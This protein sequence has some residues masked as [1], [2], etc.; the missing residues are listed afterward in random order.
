M[1]NVKHYIFLLS[2]FLFSWA[3][4]FA[5]QRFP[6]PEFETDYIQPDPTTPEPR[7][8][9]FEYLDLLIL[10]IVL[11]LAAYFALK[12]RSRK[13]I[14]WLSIFSLAYFG[15]YRE[16]C[17][18]SVGSVQNVALTLFSSEYLISISVLVFFALPLLFSLFFG[19]VFCAAACPLGVIQDLVILKPI[20]I[21]K[22]LNKVLSIFPYLYLGL[23]VLYAA[24]GTDFVICKYDPFIGFYRMG[25]NF[26]M[27]VIGISLL[28][29][30]L[31]VARPYCRFICPYGV[32]LKWTSMFS[33]YHLSITPSKCTQC[34]LCTDSCPFDAIDKPTSN[35]YNTNSRKYQKGF[36]INA[37]LLPLW[38]VIG[39]YA[40]SS[41]HEYLSTVHPDVYLA[42][43]LV[44]NPD[45]KNDTENIDIQTFMS[46][47]KSMDTLVSEAKIIQDKF[48]WGGWLLGSF[49]GLVIGLT[50]LNQ[51]VFRKKEDYEANQ[52]DCF[53]CGRCFKYCPVLE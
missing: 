25:A 21:S 7:A 19:R 8:F 50:L 33:K 2:L 1:R 4:I 44:E 30:G 10:F 16:G 45:L 24:T 22:K 29:I 6:K 18:C 47:G 35:L 28:L 31:F 15:F 41:S 49:I 36:I 51:L 32:L 40:V 9:G 5:Q 3:S 17:I 20:S 48:Y 43:L 27:I 46:S 23:A 39:G 14:L 11:I 52:G 13:G 37:L 42:K 53:S 34:H 26:T 38:I 12:S